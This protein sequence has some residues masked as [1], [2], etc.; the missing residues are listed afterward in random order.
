MSDDKFELKWEWPAGRPIAAK[1]LLRVDAIDKV[2]SGLFGLGKSPSMDGYLPDAR[3][4]RASVIAGPAGM[5]GRRLML[6]LPG[7]EARKLTVGGQAGLGLVAEQ[8]KGVGI[9]VCVAPAPD[10]AASAAQQW[11]SDWNCATN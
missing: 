7:L 10:G 4:L 5:S 1:V 8:D 6:N 2:S 11:L 9:A 3:T